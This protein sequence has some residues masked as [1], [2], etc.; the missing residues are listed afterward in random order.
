M[1]TQARRDDASR[2]SSSSSAA[3]KEKQQQRPLVVVIVGASSGIGHATAVEFAKRGAKLAL[4]ARSADTLS[5]VVTE[6]LAAGGSALGIPTDV[7]DA[8]A[9][10]K[11]ANRAVSHFGRIDVWVNAAGVGAVGRFDGVPLEANRRVIESNLLGHMHGAHVA[12]QHFRETERGLLVNLNSMGGWV[13]TPFEAAYSAS[14]FGVRG[15]S[16]SLRAEVADLPN[17]HVCDVA[18]TRVDTPG[19]ANGANYTGHRLRSVMPMLDPRR[20]GQAIVA[21]AYSAHP[22]PVT[23]LGA[24]ALPSRVAH[25][26]SPTLFGRARRWFGERN[27]EHGQPAPLSDGNLYEPSADAVIDGGIRS[28]RAEAATAAI[29]LGTVGLALGWWIGSRSR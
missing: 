1:S 17:V 2:K 16:E 26:V 20:V 10:Q 21:L 11:L 13:G 18:P 8:E 14:K 25:A 5:H 19:L 12:M 23:W 22:K 24:A 7:T 9:V 3:Q 6:C 28:A 15:L 27:L 4:A 29:V